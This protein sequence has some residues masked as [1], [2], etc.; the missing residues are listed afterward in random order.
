MNNKS[1]ELLILSLTRYYKK[2][3]H[4]I[5]K[6]TPIIKKSSGISL[7]LID[8]FV[9]NYCKKNNIILLKT[10]SNKKKEYFNIYSNYRAQLKA[11]KKLQFDPFRRRERIDF[12][13]NET[14]YIETTIGQLNFFRWFLE[15]NILD[16]V[17]EHAHEIENDMLNNQKLVKNESNV[18]YSK[19]L[20]KKMT[21]FSGQTTVSFG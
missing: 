12:Y 1:C 4:L 11:F 5:E 3:I 9:T 15:N 21:K 2:H 8:W 18:P 7:R 20:V 14:D 10:I 13:Y 6:I 17:I 19:T 16:Y